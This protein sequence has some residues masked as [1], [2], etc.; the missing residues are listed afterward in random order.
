MKNLLKSKK[1]QGTT[2]YIV[3]LA[4]A[5]GLAI[6]IFWPTLKGALNMK[7]ADLGTQITQAGK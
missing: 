1:G 7:I 4:I 2:E 3:I 5:V 6:V